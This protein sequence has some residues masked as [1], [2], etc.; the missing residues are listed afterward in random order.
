MVQGVA[1]LHSPATSIVNYTEVT[2]ALGADAVAAGAKIRLGREVVGIRLAGSEVVIDSELRPE[3][4][5]K[6]S[7][8]SSRA[9]DCRATGWPKW[10]ATART[11]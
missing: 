7:T 1:A 3:L 2:T 5:T 4:R 8:R 6:R 10:R 11:R 9:E